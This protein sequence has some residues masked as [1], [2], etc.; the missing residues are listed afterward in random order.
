MIRRF[1]QAEGI[2]PGVAPAMCSRVR[3][4][5]QFFFIRTAISANANFSIYRIKDSF[6]SIKRIKF[7]LNASPPINRKAKFLMDRSRMEGLSVSY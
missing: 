3:R 7:I 4:G 2:T 6:Y 1:P 5:Q